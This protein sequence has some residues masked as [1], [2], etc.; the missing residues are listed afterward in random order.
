MFRILAT[1]DEHLADALH[2]FCSDWVFEVK[3]CI[4]LPHVTSLLKCRSGWGSESPSMPVRAFQARSTSDARLTSLS[5]TK[6]MKKRLRAVSR[7]PCC[8][9][10]F[11]DTGVLADQPRCRRRDVGLTASAAILYHLFKPMVRI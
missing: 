8:Q 10:S 1:C 4:T 5:D 6:P 9:S 7:Q 11:A 2:L 3:Y